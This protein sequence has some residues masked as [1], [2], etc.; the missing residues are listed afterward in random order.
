MQVYCSKQ[1]KP[2]KTDYALRTGLQTGYGL[3]TGTVGAIGEYRATVDLLL[4]GYEVFK[5][6]SP[7]CSC[8]LVILRD[9]KMRRI[10]VRTAY[11]NKTTGH[12]SKR[13]TRFRADSFAWVFPDRVEYEPPLE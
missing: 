2:S 3:P 7:T 12:V 13:R 8:D 5:A 6:T 10:E 9:G 11:E 1:C 4:K